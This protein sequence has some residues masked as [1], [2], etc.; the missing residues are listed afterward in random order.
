ML[1]QIADNVLQGFTAPLLALLTILQ[2]HVQLDIFVPKAQH[3][4]LLILVLL[5]TTAQQGLMRKYF[6]KEEHISL[7]LNK[8]LAYLAQSV[9][10]AL[11]HQL[12][13]KSLKFL[14]QKGIHVPVLQ[15]I[16][17]LLVLKEHIKQQLAKLLVLNVQLVLIVHQSV[18]KL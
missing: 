13:P 12:Y 5:D 3:L 9:T 6:V 11:T 8:P 16:I 18:L 4:V 7:Q 15:W 1:R 17:Q 14:V 10:I 2:H